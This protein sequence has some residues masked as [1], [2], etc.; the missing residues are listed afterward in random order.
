MQSLLSSYLDQHVDDYFE[1]FRRD[2]FEDMDFITQLLRSAHQFY[3]RERDSSVRKALKLVVAYSL[4]LHVSFIEHTDGA[5]TVPGLV[6]DPNS[7][8]FGKML[9]PAMVNVQIKC[10]LAE[11]LRD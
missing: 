6:D 11:T 9:A 2:H 3:L 5:L 4:T 8:Y 7:K 10:I 1:T